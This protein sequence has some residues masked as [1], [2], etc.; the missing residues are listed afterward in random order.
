MCAKLASRTHLSCKCPALSMPDAG[1]SA[2]QDRNADAALP[3][4][5]CA[6]KNRDAVSRVPVL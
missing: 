4:N 6:Q 1:S 2:S 5:G 3:A